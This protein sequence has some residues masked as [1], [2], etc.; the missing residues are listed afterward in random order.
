MAEPGWL[1]DHL[2]EKLHRWRT[3]GLEGY[4]DA[5]IRDPAEMLKAY[6]EE[7]VSKLRANIGPARSAT[8]KPHLVDMANGRHFL[9]G[10][11]TPE[12]DL[13]NPY[14][15]TTSTDARF[16]VF[17]DRSY[18]WTCSVILGSLPHEELQAAS[19]L[20][21]EVAL[22]SVTINA[23]QIVE[24]KAA[25]PRSLLGEL[26]TTITLR[27]EKIARPEG[28][29][30]QLALGVSRIILEAIP[31]TAESIGLL[32]SEDSEARAQMEQTLERLVICI[33]EAPV[34][35]TPDHNIYLQNV[36]TSEFYERIL[37]HLP[38]DSAYDYI[39][40]PDA[41][42]P[43][44]GKTRMLLD[45]TPE[46]LPRLDDEARDFWRQMMKM[47]TS[48]PLQH[49]ITAKFGQRITDQHGTFWPDILMVPVLYRDFT[50]YR[51]SIHPDA[52]FKI[53]TL[54]FYLPN[55]ESQLHM[56]TSFHKKCNNGFVEVK[57]NP[58]RPNSAYA[59]VR[60]DRSWHSVHE[61]EDHGI[62]RNTLALTL[63]IKGYEYK[64][65]PRNA[66]SI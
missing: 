36:F 14:R 53:A 16:R 10:W 33:G 49:A 48:P 15:W 3:K 40:H 62:V 61:I 42:R 23:P 13:A 51:I 6:E 4:F 45:L 60:S 17:L 28:E 26:S 44:G 20:I 39:E 41:V 52:D 19:L 11:G 55:D 8:W 57:T 30:R 1:A 2:A 66:S 64:S 54:Q 12:G 7:V 50:G 25:I 21:G 18:D 46:T 34:D 63:Y 5:P 65:S 47:L 59:F 35:E 37:R 58:F 31:P 24:L 38:P 43:D 27:A 56:G 9:D 29:H 22:S 32:Q